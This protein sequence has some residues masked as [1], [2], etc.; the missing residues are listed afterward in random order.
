MVLRNILLW[1]STIALIG[2]SNPAPVAIPNDAA[3]SAEIAQLDQMVFNAY[4]QCDM[5]IFSQYFA[6]NVEF[7]HD[8]GGVTFD[9]GSVIAN[10]RKYICH[11][12]RRV[13]V[14]GSLQVYPIKNF[15]AIEEGEHLFCQIDGECEGAA[16]FLMVWRKTGSH[17]QITR[18]I[19]F[20]HRALTA[21]ESPNAQQVAH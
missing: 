14:T 2:A 3:L 19:S 18:V 9:R 16:K 6:P 13:L 4:N 8:K 1:T 5:A 11:R 15:G 21:A 10:T 20:G 7:Y 17:W 12:V